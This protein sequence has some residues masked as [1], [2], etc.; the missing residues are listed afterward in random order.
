MVGLSLLQGGAA[1]LREPLGWRQ[2]VRGRGGWDVLM[3]GHKR[4]SVNGH[5]FPFL[6]PD[7]PCDGSID[8]L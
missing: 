3:W 6:P 8:E 4:R 1:V 2:E 5:P 7:P